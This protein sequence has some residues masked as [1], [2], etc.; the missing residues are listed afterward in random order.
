MMFEGCRSPSSNNKYKGFGQRITCDAI[1][2]QN[3]SWISIACKG[4]NNNK[5]NPCH[6]LAD[7]Q[8]D[9]PEQAKKT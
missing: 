2:T 8:Q 6:F 5:G 4:T 1:M 7:D 9:G 3:R